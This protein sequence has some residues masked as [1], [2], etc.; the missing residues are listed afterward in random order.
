MLG[1]QA[2]SQFV[3]IKK[4][5][6]SILIYHKHS[7]PLRLKTHLVACNKSIKD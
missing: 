7:L 6:I 5:K 3:N 1:Y 2:S 4:N